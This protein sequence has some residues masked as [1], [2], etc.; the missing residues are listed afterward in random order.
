MIKEYSDY[1]IEITLKSPIITRFQSDTIFGHICWAIRMLK[2]DGDDRLRDFISSYENHKQTPPL[3]VSNGFPKGML[4]KPVLLPIA[5]DDLKTIVGKEDIIKNSFIIK[6]IK[7]TELILKDDFK[8]LQKEK[9][10]SLKLFNRMYESIETIKKEMQNEQAMIVQHNSV[11][12]IEN[13]VKR[14]LYAQKELFYDEESHNSGKFEIYL[15][16]CF[17]DKNDLKRIFDYIKEDGFGRDKSTGKGH[18]DFKINEGIDLQESENPNAFMTLSSFIPSQNDPT[19]GHY[20]IIHKFG[21]LGGLYA[22]GISEVY[23]NPFK[24]PLIMFS[25]GSTFYDGAYQTGKVYGSLLSDV[26]QNN[27]IRH[28]AYAF[29]IGIKIEDKNEDV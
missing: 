1:T 26:H 10:T 21:K 12:R 4:P 11:N 25:A 9:I 22:K 15:K 28:Y 24:K 20:N 7:K 27:E 19:V 29:P 18:F 5:Q 6:N 14:G 13:I 8:A 23:G 16:T 17:F 3:L 2:W